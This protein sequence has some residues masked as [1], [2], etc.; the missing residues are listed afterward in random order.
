MTALILREDGKR[1][2]DPNAQQGGDSRDLCPQPKE[3]AHAE[4]HKTTPPTRAWIQN[5]SAT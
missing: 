4:L 3:E 2:K 5:C 1:P